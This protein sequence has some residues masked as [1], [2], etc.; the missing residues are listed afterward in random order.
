MSKD[1]RNGVTMERQ[2]SEIEH[3]RSPK[4]NSTRGRREYFSRGGGWRSQEDG[5][6]KG[7]NGGDDGKQTW[8]KKVVPVGL[9]EHVGKMKDHV[10]E[11][12]SRVASG[13]EFTARCPGQQ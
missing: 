4:L 9:T 1:L 2:L 6:E 10:L 12:E 5:R 7:E 8:V 13:Y 3:A 11:W